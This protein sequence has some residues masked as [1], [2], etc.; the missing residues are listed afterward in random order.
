MLLRTQASQAPLRASPTSSPE[1]VAASLE[2]PDSKAVVVAA[3][4]SYSSFA[5]PAAENSHIPPVT[6]MQQ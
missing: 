5:V 1:M 3:L 6:C 2:L 4:H